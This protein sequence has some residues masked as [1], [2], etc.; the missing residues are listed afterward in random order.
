MAN[1]VTS[2]P[3]LLSLRD[4]A[5]RVRLPVSALRTEIRKGRLTPIVVAGKFYLTEG[6]ISEFIAS[7]H[8]PRGR[9]SIS[10]PEKDDQESGSSETR[11]LKLA[12]SAARATVAELKKNL[13]PTSPRSTGQTH[14]RRG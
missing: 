1:A 7:C 14:A 8:E 2:L 4:A 3:E 11:E 13:R 6:L 9:G 12:Q 5:D 10:D